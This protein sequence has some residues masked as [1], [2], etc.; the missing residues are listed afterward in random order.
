MLGSLQVL[1]RHS[2][3]AVVLTLTSFS[4]SSITSQRLL[5]MAAYLAPLA[6][7]MPSSSQGLVKEAADGCAPQS[8]GGTS[9]HGPSRQAAACGN[10]SFACSPQARMHTWDTCCAGH[11]FL[12]S[13]GHCGQPHRVAQVCAQTLRTRF[14]LL[15]CAAE[16]IVKVLALMAFLP[17]SFRLD[18]QL[19][20][21]TAIFARGLLPAHQVSK[22]SSVPLA[23]RHPGPHIGHSLQSVLQ[24]TK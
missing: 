21:C 12:R 5:R 23:C 3:N 4:R 1:P 24:W 15:L 22:A 16:E 20:P 7:C 18:G 2:L 9:S 10:D 19:A 17:L 14:L 13:S 6:T 11:Q 8:C